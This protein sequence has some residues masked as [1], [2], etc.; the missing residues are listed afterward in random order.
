MREDWESESRYKVNRYGKSRYTGGSRSVKRGRKKR[1]RRRQLILKSILC[2]ALIIP[3]VMA[4]LWAKDKISGKSSLAVLAL[5]N[6]KVREIMANKDQYPDQLVELLENNEETV[7]FVYD[8]PEKKDTAPADTVGDVTQG[9]IPLLLQWDERWGYAYYADDMIAVNGC[10][11]TAIA[12]VAAGLT[13]D[14]TITPYKVAQFAAENGYYAGDAGTS[15]SLMTEG[16]RRF[17]ICGEEM[18]LGESEIFSA[19]ENGHPVICSMRPGDFTTT[20]HFIVLTGVED[21]KIRVNDPNSQARSEK[22]WDYS[23]LEYQINNL[24][25]YTAQ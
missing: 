6:P 4:A 16:A 21:G 24:W 19:L 12:M 3:M 17:G 22:L 5:T 7:D 15:W 11:P 23:R 20:G 25:V 10:G 1:R 8:Y 9:E 13:G 14:N 18:G 2:V